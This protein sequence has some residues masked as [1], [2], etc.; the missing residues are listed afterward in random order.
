[1]IF[2]GHKKGTLKKFP[3]FLFVMLNVGGIEGEVR[4]CHPRKKEEE[5]ILKYLKSFK[6]VDVKFWLLLGAFLMFVYF[7][8]QLRVNL[9]F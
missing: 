7:F 8:A 9:L 2:L 3:P 5:R 6:A 4:K 1:M